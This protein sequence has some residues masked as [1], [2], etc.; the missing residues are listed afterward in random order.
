MTV[1]RMLSVA[2]ACA[3]VHTVS[4]QQGD[5]L[6]AAP[7]ARST[8][9]RLTHEARDTDT[10]KSNLRFPRWRP[11]PAASA[12]IA[13]LLVPGTGQLMLGQDRFIVY[14]ALEG[15]SWWQF[16]KA[17]RERSQQESEFRDLA[18]RVARAHLSANGPDGDWQYYETMRDYDESGQFSRS[19][20]QLLPETDTA[21]WN[22]RTW[23]L[24]K[25]LTTDSVSALAFYRDHAYGPDM[26]WSWRNAGLQKGLF[27]Q[28]T[29]K[30]NDANRAM[31][32]YLMAIAANHLVSMV[33]AFATF[34]LEVRPVGN[35]RT[36][37]GARVSW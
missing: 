4:G 3:A 5:G 10:A 28:A 26:A 35:G 29:D 18:R 17:S 24:A 19:D 36:A 25:G 9:R 22:G 37:V 13:S 20:T 30:R 16:L 7:A 33:D 11:L 21:T 23:Q 1:A 12:P 15:L 8:A 2:A 31:N 27:T 14:A 32:N 34:R 6:R